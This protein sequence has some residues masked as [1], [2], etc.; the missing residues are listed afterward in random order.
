MR[1]NTHVLH[2]IQKLAGQKKLNKL[3]QQWMPL[4]NGSPALAYDI[5]W[6]YSVFEPWGFT[7]QYRPNIEYILFFFE[8]FSF[9]LSVSFHQ[10]SRT[11]HG[12]YFYAVCT[13][14]CHTIIQY[15][16]TK[17][18]FSKFIFL[19]L[20]FWVC[21]TLFYLQG[22]L[23]WCMLHL[24]YHNCIYSRLPEDEPSVSKYVEDIKIKNY[25]VHFVGLYSVI[26]LLVLTRRTD[27]Q[28]LGSFWNQWMLFR[29]SGSI[30]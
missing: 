17:C 12:Y 29:N 9:P 8:N 11:I 5:T 19:I 4:A 16:P 3:R 10:R 21:R 18:I 27:G 13:V 24:P 30:G 15:K 6:S 23:Y 20:I 7:A 22:C 1:L 25:I 14:H 2:N 26:H 28:N